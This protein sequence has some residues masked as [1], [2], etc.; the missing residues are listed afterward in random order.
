M[1]AKPLFGLESWELGHP[2]ISIKDRTCKYKTSFG[3][4]RKLDFCVKYWK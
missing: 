4:F 3:V 2:N 1:S